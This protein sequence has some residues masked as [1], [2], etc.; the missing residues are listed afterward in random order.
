MKRKIYLI[1]TVLLAT[2]MLFM[3]ASCNAKNLGSAPKDEGNIGNN[4]NKP[5][6]P[7]YGD[8]NNEAVED[9]AP[10]APDEEIKDSVTNPFVENPFVSTEKN[11]V[12]TLSADVD[13]ASY[14]YFRKLVNSGYSWAE[15]S[16]F[17]SI[18]RNFSIISNTQQSN[19]VRMSFSRSILY[20]SPARGTK[21]TCSSL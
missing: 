14:T 16:R 11:N 10:S 8:M 5:T 6:Y 12:S 20:C 1:L 15:L 19:R 13:T 21:T 4:S 9:V 2:V 17:S 7:N 18:Q 3:L